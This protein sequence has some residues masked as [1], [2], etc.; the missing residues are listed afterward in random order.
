[1]LQNNYFFPLIKIEENNSVKYIYIRMPVIFNEY[2][3]ADT[4]LLFVLYSVQFN[5]TVS[6]EKRA[7]TEIDLAVC[8][9]PI[10]L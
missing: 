7:S 10:L 1:M 4:I 3:M 9:N 5:I 6:T 8:L 2:R